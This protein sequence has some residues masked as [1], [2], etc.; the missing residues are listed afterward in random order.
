MAMTRVESAEQVMPQMKWVVRGVAQ[1]SDEKFQEARQ[2]Q[3][4]MEEGEMVD[5]NEVRARTSDGFVRE[6]TVGIRKISISSNGRYISRGREGDE[7]GI[8]MII[9]SMM[10]GFFL[11]VGF[12]VLW[13]CGFGSGWRMGIDDKVG[14]E[15]EE[16]LEGEIRIRFSCCCCCCCCCFW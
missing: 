6:F 12:R 11:C 1:G 10:M 13:R 15:L 7:G 16:T 2:D 4:E 8:D 9:I 5:F 3:G 14:N